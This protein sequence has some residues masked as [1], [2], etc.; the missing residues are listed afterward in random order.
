MLHAI[1]QEHRSKPLP[2]DIE[3]QV[4]TNTTEIWQ[5]GQPQPKSCD[6]VFAYWQK[7][8]GLSSKVAEIRFWNAIE[9]RNFGLARYAQKSITD[10]S[11]LRDADLFW[12]V[13]KNP[14]KN[15]T[16]K[17][18]NKENPHHEQIIEYALKRLTSSDLHAAITRWLQLREQLD[19]NPVQ[20]ASLNRYLSIKLATRFD[21][22]ALSLIAALDPGYQD[23]EVTE[24][25]IRLALSE[26]NW[27]ETAVFISKL[28][29]HAQ[30][31]SRWQY[32]L[33]VANEHLLGKRQHQHFEKIAQDRSYY[34]FLASEQLKQSFKLNNEPSQLPAALKAELLSHPTVQRIQELV[35]HGE[36]YY[37]RQEW[38]DLFP[39]LPEIKQH[40]LAHLARDWNWHS[41][42]IMAAAALQKWNDLTLRF[43]VQYHHL[44]QQF[45]HLSKIPLTWALSITRQESAFN[46]EARSGVGAMGLMQLM[47]KTARQTAKKQQEPLDSDDQL[48]E[49]ETN[50]ALGTAYLG[51]M[52]ERFNGSRIYATAAYNAGPSR[53]DRWIK[54]RGH[55]PLDIWI[56]LI[57]F[58]ETRRYVQ[59]VLE[60]GVVYDL[61]AKRPARLL[62]DNEVDLLTLSLLYAEKT[63][64]SNSQAF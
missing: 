8:G 15:L 44:Y 2:V 28:E 18:L 19:L 41:Q 56:E 39:T 57:P 9:A 38:N 11:A 46:H 42:A 62:Q 10:K 37:A 26:F 30:N 4:M 31:S 33:A 58:N 7:K 12:L 25:R 55:L 17:L 60:Y 50:I 21:P 20:Q 47:P 48:L 40:A 32:W 53:V 3:H 6:P 23:N 16:A 1:L 34:G 49:P 27:Q 36:Y 51:Q 61:L 13:R 5:Q 59:R 52:L 54:A 14:A 35:F 43:P 64:S 63:G 24:W 45:S 29:P 22:Q